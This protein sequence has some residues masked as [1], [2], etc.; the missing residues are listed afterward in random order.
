M[1]V[2]F[3][4]HRNFF[5]IFRFNVNFVDWKGRAALSQRKIGNSRANISQ[6][7]FRTKIWSWYTQNIL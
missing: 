1:L 5:H 2:I 7:D 3:Y 6:A 4:S